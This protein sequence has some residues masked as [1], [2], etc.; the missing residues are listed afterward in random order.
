MPLCEGTVFYAFH[1]EHF[2]KIISWDK[3]Y[4]KHILGDSAP[5]NISVLVK[6]GV[7]LCKLIS[8]EQVTLSWQP[9]EQET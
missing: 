1:E 3:C 5:L 8:L 2:S 7:S 6:V 9:H 4:K